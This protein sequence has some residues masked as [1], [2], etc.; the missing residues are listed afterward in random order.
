GSG[1][2]SDI[3]NAITFAADNGAK[4]INMSLGAN[5]T[6]GCPSTTQDAINYAFNAGVFVAAAAGNSGTTEVSYPAGCSNVVSVGATDNADAI[7]NFSQHPP[8]AT[9]GV[10]LAAP[11]VNI[12]S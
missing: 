1:Q 10:D 2:F 4:L 5:L 11:G 9:T 3:A 6:T 8:S 7:A 12:A